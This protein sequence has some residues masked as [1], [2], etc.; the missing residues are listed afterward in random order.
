MLKPGAKLE[1][2]SEIAKRY[3]VA[4]VTAQAALKQL[5]KEGLI[6]RTQK[7]GTYVSQSEGSKKINHDVLIIGNT[8][9]KFWLE[10]YFKILVELKKDGI[11]SQCIDVHT[12]QSELREILKTKYLMVILSEH[13]HA[14]IIQD[15]FP[16]HNVISL[17]AHK[18]LQFKGHIVCSN[19]YFA[20]YEGTMHLIKNGYENI[21]CLCNAGKCNVESDIRRFVN[22]E[23]VAG[24]H[25]AL[26]E[27][28]LSTMLMSYPVTGSAE[29]IIT[30]FLKAGKIPDA[31]VSSLDHRSKELVEVIE[32][33]DLKV[34][35]DIALVS[36]GNSVW[37]E[38][39][40]FTSFDF[41]RDKMA[42][43]CI[44]IIKEMEGGR[45]Q[46]D[47][48]ICRNILPKMIVRSSCQTP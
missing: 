24:Y 29:E 18:P 4:L 31:V 33:F 14:N 46:E 39:F 42:K 3:S 44:E 7:K 27:N 2:T 35:D 17:S 32:Q 30:K 47:E 6:V 1:S 25:R 23:F 43:A 11:N 37:S 26:Q 8:N 36:T 38:A 16:E 41:Q 5:T 22:N 40:K 48:F 10:L 19:P 28:K 15:E 9:D 13:F 20:A 21:A 45:I 12:E 34:P